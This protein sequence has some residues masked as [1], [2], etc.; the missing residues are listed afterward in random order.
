M[1]LMVQILNHHHFFMAFSPQF[2][3]FMETSSDS[4][5]AKSI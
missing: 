4:C 3:D 1:D 5:E 2:T